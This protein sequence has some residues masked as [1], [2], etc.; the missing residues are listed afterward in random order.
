MRR[1]ALVN[2]VAVAILFSASAV[3]AGQPDLASADWSL[4]AAHNLAKNPPAP[5]AVV[6]FLRKLNGT[7]EYPDHVCYARFADLRGSGTLSL[8]VSE[9]GGKYCDPLVI[10]R[11]AGGYQKYSFENTTS[12]AGGIDVADLGRD[13]H[14]E[15]IVETTL[16]GSSPTLASCLPTLEVIY[17]WTGTNYTDVSS[18]YKSYYENAFATLRKKTASEKAEDQQVAEQMAK[19]NAEIEKLPKSPGEPPPGPPSAPQDRD[20]PHCS[21]LEAAKLER[22]LG[23]SD[24]AGI[25]DAIKWSQSTEAENREVA[26][27]LFADIGTPEALE[28]LRALSR[29]PDS[30]V[31]S[32][33]KDDLV[34]LGP[35]L[36][37]ARREALAAPP[38]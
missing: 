34:H 21:E 20:L 27:D 10:D 23:I 17:A 38:H 19:I 8:V 22:M 3:S 5:E 35:R 13:G 28:H 16:A 9:S 25:G 30:R 15:I 24:S 31:A 4:H 12:Y 36:Y 2:A 11:T 29:D 6:T 26:A 14:Q 32:W 37:V 18:S 1:V 33:A 7:P